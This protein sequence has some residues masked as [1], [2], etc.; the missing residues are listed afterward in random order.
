[1]TTDRPTL[2]APTATELEEAR[3]DLRTLCEVMQA[4]IAERKAK[5][6]LDK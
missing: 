5:K 3:K 2:R 4:R 1:M 6:A